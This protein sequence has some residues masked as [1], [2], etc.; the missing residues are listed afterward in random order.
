MAWPDIVAVTIAYL[1]GLSS[2][3]G[4]TVANEVPSTMPTKLLQVRR[5]GGTKAPPVRDRGRLDLIAW[6]NTSAE[7]MALA[8]LARTEVNALRG[9]TTGGVTIY[10]IEEFLGPRQADDPVTGK[11]RV[12]QTQTLTFRADEAIR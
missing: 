10:L 11:K 2:L 8:L 7:A 9:T 4:V 5:V 12:M 6:A 3:N 1:D